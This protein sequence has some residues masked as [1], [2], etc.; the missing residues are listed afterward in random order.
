MKNQENS[1]FDSILFKN[2]RPL[3]RAA[4][5][6]TLLLVAV[7]LVNIQP[8][9]A[10]AV[11]IGTY[12]QCANDNGIGYPDEG[13]DWINGNLNS[14]NSAYQEG[15]ATVQRLWLNGF[16]PGSTHTIT[17]SYGT[18]KGGKHAYDFLTTWNLSENWI[19]LADRC[20]DITGCITAAPD[21][22][23]IPD[24]PIVPNAYFVPA[25][26]QFVMHGGDLTAA[27][28]PTIFSGTYTG[29]SETRITISFTVGPSNGSMCETKGQTT[30]CGVVLWFGGHVA[31]QL[32]WGTGTS[33]ANIN[34]SP[35]HV[36]FVEMDGASVG[37]RDN[38][39]Q[40]G[41]PTADELSAFDA[42]WN[43]ATAQIDLSWESATEHN[44][45]G[46]NVWRK[47]GKNNWRQL[48]TDLI[49]AKNPGSLTGA[50]YEYADSAVKPGKMHKY[51]LEVVRADGSTS[52]SDK[53]KVKVPKE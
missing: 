43:E 46:Y 24:D 15:D 49:E 37:Q 35:Y 41:A 38:Q 29:D 3:R 11:A 47:R 7:L 12:D 18:T 2:Q 36:A 10:L 42:N 13:C 34:G 6:L 21:A 51:R 28:T 19:T 27:T 8:Q 52:T 9:L 45:I 48:N 20:Q 30:T 4:V 25:S 5:V 44:I 50:S 31:R 17:L 33:A 16:V 53:V 22:L 26:R 32:D 1:Y 40:L 23:N 39:M 14:N